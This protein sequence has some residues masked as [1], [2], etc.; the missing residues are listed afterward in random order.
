MV[1][2]PEVSRH[3]MLS[4]MR[5]A[6]EVAEETASQYFREWKKDG[7]RVTA[8]F[9]YEGAQTVRDRLVTLIN[10]LEALT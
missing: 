4:V 2:K 8:A 6:A 1:I 10:E 3:I 7:G 5:V 9:Q